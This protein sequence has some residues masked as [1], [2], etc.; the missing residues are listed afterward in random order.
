MKYFFLVWGNLMRKK[1][2][3]V[4][5]LLSITVAFILFGYLSAV[6]E[7]LN[8]GVSVAGADRLV[9]RHKIS[10]IQLLPI[11]Y[12]ARMARIEGIERVAHATWFGGVY[13]TP[14]N[15]FAQMAVEPEDFMSLYPE[16]LL[17]KAQM[18][19]WK[20]TRTGAIVGRKTAERYGF[21]VGDRVPLQAT[22][23][24]QKNGN[25][26]WE[27]DVVGIYEGDGP[28]VDETQFLFRY[29]Y[30][31]EARKGGEGE[32][33]WYVVRVGDPDRAEA[34]ARE[35]DGEFANSSAE[36]KAET[37]GAFVQG[38]AKQIGNIGAIMIAI[39]SAVFFTILLVAGNTM[40]QAVR[41]R[42]VEIGVLKS[43][44]FDDARILFLVLAES[45]S[46]ALIGGGAGLAVAWLLIAAG[47][48]TGGGLPIF[49][50]PEQRIALGVLLALGLGM[51]TGMVPAIRAMTLPI[52]EALRR[53]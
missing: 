49:F 4:L 2:R 9:V 16:F 53:Q 28:G 34:I 24:Q 3:T 43:I 33:G 10:L 48:P 51:M 23:W 26:A 39:M 13:Q 7:A 1:V 50:F 41:E 38:F 18:A 37:E 19:A 32:I 30:F 31:D 20:K 14:R 12:Q 47:D 44:G 17:P 42:I 11:S 22:I 52:A 46:V 36:T 45:C 21:K 5:T 15:F 27:F 6:E 25:P 29:D 8:V 35:I 40:A